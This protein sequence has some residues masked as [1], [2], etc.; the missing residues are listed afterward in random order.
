MAF[1]YQPFATTAIFLRL[2]LISSTA[3]KTPATS[4]GLKLLSLKEVEMA[5]LNV[6]VFVSLI[7]ISFSAAAKS[8]YFLTVIAPA[9][10]R[11]EDS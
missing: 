8:S 2:I 5:T 4:G 9:A 10:G 6:R 1:S 7:C 3:E 11:L